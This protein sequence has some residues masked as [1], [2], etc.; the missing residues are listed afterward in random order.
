MTERPSVLVRKEYPAD[1]GAIHGLV[2]AAF[3]SPSEAELVDALRAAGRLSISLVAVEDGAF[4]GHVAFS[5]I[6]VDD[7]TLGLGLGPLAVRADRRRRGIGERL[8]RDG[9]ALCRN[10]AVGLV[11]V[12]GDPR[13]YARFGFEAA[14]RHELRSEYDDAG[15][16]FQAVELVHGTI[17]PGG[18]LVRY[19]SEFAHVGA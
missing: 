4:V 12:L 17:R 6:T 14:R 9:L 18:G 11:V 19:C 2:A 1:I 10:A 15:D 8:V 5:P 16:A 3:P 7:A 13:Y